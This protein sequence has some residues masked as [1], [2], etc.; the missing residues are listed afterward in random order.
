MPPRAAA[1]A[2]ATT[3][4]GLRLS[5]VAEQLRAV[6]AEMSALN[7]LGMLGRAGE[8][9]VS[10]RAGQPWRL[11]AAAQAAAGG[12]R[13]RVASGFQAVDIP[14]V[15]RPPGNH[16]RLAAATS[17]AAARCSPL[18]PAA[19]ARRP[20]PAARR[21]PRQYHPPCAAVTGRPAA[22]SAKRGSASGDADRVLV[23][24]GGRVVRGDGA[25]AKDRRRGQG[26]RA[27]LGVR[28]VERG[29]VRRGSRVRGWRP[30]VATARAANGIVALRRRGPP[31]YFQTP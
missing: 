2:L 16:C 22:P 8:G 19:A 30:E 1:A 6:A 18:P 11:R 3:S 29:V 23:E 12:P 26:P 7:A 15:R 17:P 24:R 21:P 20:P 31:T 4:G 5:L 13:Q 9:V 14:L 25:A 27:H 10:G 28:R